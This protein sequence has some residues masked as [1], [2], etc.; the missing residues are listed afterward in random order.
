MI[1]SITLRNFKTYKKNYFIPLS[2]NRNL[3]SLIGDNGIGKSS[4]LEALNTF[5]KDKKWNV[6]VAVRKNIKLDS[7]IV[8]V[9]LIPLSKLENSPNFTLAK[10]ISDYIWNF[11]PADANSAVRKT[12]DPFILQR[13]ELKRN[14]NPDNH[15]LIPLGE[16]LHNK[17]KE[18]TFGVFRSNKLINLLFPEDSVNKK[19]ISDKDLE[20]LGKL[21]EEIKEL[22]H[23][24]YIPKDIDP[25]EFVKLETEEIQEL[26]GESLNE[27]INS[28]VPTKELKKINTNLN[29]FLQK[30][31][32]E[33]AD[34]EFR[35]SERRQINIKKS[36]INNLI[37]SAFFGIRSLFKKEGEQWINM[38]DLSSGEK[39]KAII[40]VAHNLITKHRKNSDNLIIAIDEPESSLHI[41][42]CFDQFQKLFE[43]SKSIN[44]LLFSTHWYGFIPIIELGSVT[45]ITKKD[46]EHKFDNLDI[47]NYREQI[48]FKKKESNGKLPFDIRL[49][50]INDFIQTLISS[51]IDKKEYN[52]IICEGSSEKI[53]FEYYF[54]QIGQ[55]KNLNIIPVG[56]AGEVK[57]VYENFY[58]AVKDFKS[59]LSGRIAFLTD[60][61][62][63]LT[64]FE[65]YN[66]PNTLVKRIVNI[67]A[68]QKCKLVKVDG[69][70]I[71]PATDI[72]KVLNGKIFLQTINEFKDDYPKIA[73]LPNKISSPQDGLNSF[74]ALD[75]KRTENLIVEDFFKEPG[76]KFNFAK[77]YIE[78]CN[79]ANESLSLEWMKEVKGFFNNKKN[80]EIIIE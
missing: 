45:S 30:V 10:K 1:V 65:T 6:N 56:G 51:L 60:T 16:K 24:I 28:A 53:Y 20:T 34:Y 52:W 48:K 80:S 17:K 59:E 77:R 50:S 29:E 47:E 27:V 8:P 35:T 73:F 32:D 78:N 26:M 75:L 57:R 76:V 36:D 13:E 19:D 2:S 62:A 11:D 15:L 66:L 5:F 68:E 4:V 63:Q 7:V 3:C 21:L 41:S 43:L 18:C 54:K 72:E 64:K 67:E 37:I 44:Q 22:Y 23:Y 39:Q 12:V 74:F 40:E 61:D 71:S 38:S 79:K 9:F 25:T 33:L 70:P 58:I 31:S 42:A 46:S 14:Y 55:I 49:K 69:N